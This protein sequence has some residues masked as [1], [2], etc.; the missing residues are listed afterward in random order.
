[1]IR[2]GEWWL[3]PKNVLQGEF[4][5]PREHEK[6]IFTDA[7]NAG[8]GAHLD[9]DSTGG[10]WSH[11]ERHLHINLLEMK[12]VFLALHFFKP[13]CKNNR[14]LIASVRSIEV[15]NSFFLR[16]AR[17]DSGVSI[18]NLHVARNLL[19]QLLLASSGCL[20]LGPGINDCRNPD[21]LVFERCRL[22]FCEVS[23][24]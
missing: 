21:C 23:L 7:S 10:V 19:R 1:M 22:H 9:H 20:V 13:T 15:T 8:W 3:D 4:F 17:M 24:E 14:V 16:E 18:L 2:H 11:T 5:H 12:A 6:L